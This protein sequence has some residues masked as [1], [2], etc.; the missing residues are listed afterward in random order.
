MSKILI[1]GA[2]F[3]GAIT[4]L[5]IGRRSKIIGSLNYQFLRDDKYLRRKSVECNKFFAVGAKSYGSLKFKLNNGIM[6]DRLI[7]GGNSNVWGGNIN[8]KKI[9]QNLLRKLEKKNLV[10]K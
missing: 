2:G 7:V 9:P 10:F 5:L 1:I 6:H 3:T 8:I 4:K